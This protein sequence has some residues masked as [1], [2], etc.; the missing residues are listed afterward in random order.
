MK[1]LKW[2][3]VILILVFLLGLNFT[4]LLTGNS[5]KVAAAPL[6]PGEPAQGEIYV[7]NVVTPTSAPSTAGC[8]GLGGGGTSTAGKP[9]CH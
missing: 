7:G 4:P 3:A 2:G 5:Q 8:C 6:S 9:S 1:Y